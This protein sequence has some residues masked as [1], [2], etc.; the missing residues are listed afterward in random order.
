MGSHTL[1]QPSFL[2]LVN[3]CCTREADVVDALSKTME[4]TVP[5]WTGPVAGRADH[6]DG[7]ICQ[8]LQLPCLK[9]FSGQGSP[10]SCTR[11][12]G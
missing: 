10:L 9:T 12:H 8:Q 1:Y 4:H 3:V 7:F 6:G 5:T 11:G 2:S